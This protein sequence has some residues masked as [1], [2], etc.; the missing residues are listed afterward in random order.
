MMGFDSWG[1]RAKSCLDGGGTSVGQSDS[2]LQKKQKST[3]FLLTIFI[4]IAME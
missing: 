2:S 1:D 3:G 4:R